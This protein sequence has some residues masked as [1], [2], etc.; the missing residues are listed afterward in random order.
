M[1]NFQTITDKKW[2][3]GVLAPNGKIYGIPNNSN[4]IIEITTDTYG[5]SL[6]NTNKTNTEKWKGGVLANN[7]FI[8]TIPHYENSI[9]YFGSKAS[10]IDENMTLSRYLNKF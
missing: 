8:Y 1:K 6:I 4:L 2:S 7:G 9:L 10:N 5:I 3:G